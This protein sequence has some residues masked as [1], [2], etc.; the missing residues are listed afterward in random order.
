MIFPLA[1]LVIGAALGLLAARARGGKALD[2]AQWAAVFAI[3]G[4]VLGL[5]V[6][7]FID[8]AMA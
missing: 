6:V 5:F 4:A 2:L 1:G 8:R 3:M 7:I